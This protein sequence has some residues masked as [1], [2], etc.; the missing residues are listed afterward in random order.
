MGTDF[1]RVNNDVS[2]A[3]QVEP[4]HPLSG[5]SEVRIQDRWDTLRQ[6]LRLPH[7]QSHHVFHLGQNNI[8]TGWTLDSFTSFDMTRSIL[9]VCLEH[10]RN[11]ISKLQS[12]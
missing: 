9:V 4:N 1:T 8:S 7:P 11:G 6:A 5:N 3:E 12:N 2:P 10:L